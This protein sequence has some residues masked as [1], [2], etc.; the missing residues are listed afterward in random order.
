MARITPIPSRTF[1]KFLTHIGCKEIRQ[2]GRHIIFSYPNIKRPVVIQANTT[3]PVFIIMNNLR[4]LKISH[5]EY[6][7]ILERI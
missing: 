6:L 5:N 1:I 4:L 7:R 3:L 2:K